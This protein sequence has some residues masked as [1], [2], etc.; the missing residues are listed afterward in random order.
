MSTLLANDLETFS[1]LR[2]AL[3]LGRIVTGDD[4]DDMVDVEERVNDGARPFWAVARFTHVSVFNFSH[5]PLS[6]PFL[7]FLLAS[8]SR[9]THEIAHTIAEIGR[10]LNLQAKAQ[11]APT[12]SFLF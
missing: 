6:S 3:E 9:K 1:S 12:S 8:Y 10:Y 5:E 4:G 7:Y 2:T 11:K